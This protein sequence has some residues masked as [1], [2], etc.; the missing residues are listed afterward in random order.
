MKQY[1][2]KEAK[3]E[4]KKELLDIIKPQD[5][6]LIVIKSVSQSGMCRRMRV[7]TKDFNDITFWV[8]RACDISMND[9]GLKIDGCGMDMTFWLADYI[10]Q[11]LWSGNDKAKKLFLGNGGT[12]IRW[13]VI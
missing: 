9:V 13:N 12:C 2:T 1:T 8:S 11:V 10:S 4:A 6:I 5:T 3:Q 7:L